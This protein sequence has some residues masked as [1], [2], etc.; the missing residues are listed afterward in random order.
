MDCAKSGGFTSTVDVTV[1]VGSSFTIGGRGGSGRSELATTTS[2]FL[3]SVAVIFL[4]V[5]AIVAAI[6]VVI[7]A[8]TLV[9]DFDSDVTLGSGSNVLHARTA[10]LRRWS[11]SW[12]W[13]SRCLASDSLASDCLAFEVGEAIA[14]AKTAKTVTDREDVAVA[15]CSGNFVE[16]DLQ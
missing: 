16:V 2:S 1:T 4:V 9:G 14:V 11:W 15:Q 8:L 12:G 7:V 6:V 10:S 5:V 3:G 13:G